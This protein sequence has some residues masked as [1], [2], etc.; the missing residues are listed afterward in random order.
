MIP[1]ELL[2]T[3]SSLVI[4]ILQASTDLIAVRETPP[5]SNRGEDIDRW[6]KKFGSPLGSFWCALMQGEI[7][8]RS[9]SWRPTHDVGSCDEW[10]LQGEQAGLI[11]KAPRPGAIV[12]Y[13]N[14]MRLTSGRYKGRLDAVHIGRVIQ[15]DPRALSIEGNT[16]LGKYDREGFVCGLKEVD[17]ARVLCYLAPVPANYQRAA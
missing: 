6:A 1:A 4:N 9:E 17:R 5:G 12:L 14:G 16:T 13:T 11:I 7:A 2:R 10:Y 15:P 8:D 3:E